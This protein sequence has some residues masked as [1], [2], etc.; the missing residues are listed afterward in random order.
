MFRSTHG[1]EVRR[2]RKAL[3]FFVFFVQE[4]RGLATSCST[5]TS[6]PPE[7]SLREFFEYT[8]AEYTQLS[9]YSTQQSRGF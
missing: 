6:H 2:G 8:I 5:S 1:V 3:V 4:P 9:G 7:G